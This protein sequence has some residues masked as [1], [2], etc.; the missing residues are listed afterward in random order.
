MGQ[1]GSRSSQDITTISFD[2]QDE[3]TSSGAGAELEPCCE[4]EAAARASHRT[5]GAVRRASTRPPSSA[6]GVS[7]LDA[8]EAA[9][10][11]DSSPQQRVHPANET[12]PL[13]GSSK[14][15]RGQTTGG[16]QRRRPQPNLAIRRGAK[17]LASSHQARI[18]DGPVGYSGALVSTSG[19]PGAG[20]CCCC[21][22]T[23]SAESAPSC[24]HSFGVGGAGYEDERADCCHTE[25][26][27]ERRSTDYQTFVATSRPLASGSYVKPLRA[28]AVVVAP[29]S[30][31]RP[32]MKSSQTNSTSSGG[33]ACVQSAS[34]PVCRSS[35][36]STTTRRSG[37]Q[38][39]ECCDKLIDSCSSSVSP[40]SSNG[41]ELPP[42]GSAHS[43]DHVENDE[44]Q[45]AAASHEKGARRSTATPSTI[46]DAGIRGGDKAHVADKES[47]NS[48][49]ATNTAGLNTNDDSS[50]S[51]TTNNKAKQEEQQ[52]TSYDEGNQNLI[53]PPTASITTSEKRAESQFKQS[54]QPTKLLPAPQPP[55]PPSTD[56]L[57]WNELVLKYGR[58]SQ[59]R[60][61]ESLTIKGA[62]CE[63]PDGDGQFVVGGAPPP[64]PSSRASHQRHNSQQYKQQA[65]G[66]SQQDQYTTSSASTT[67]A[68]VN[69]P[70]RLKGSGPSS[71]SCFCHVLCALAQTLFPILGAFE[72]YSLPGDLFTDLAAGFT[73]AILHI[74]QGMAYGL[75]SGVEPIYGL[76]V[77][78]IPVAVMS[79]MSKSRHVS[80][81]TFAI[82][83][84]LLVNT[85]SEVRSTIR[86]EQASLISANISSPPLVMTDN[87]QPP[88]AMQA[89]QHKSQLLRQ[90]LQQ[91]QHQAPT[92]MNDLSDELVGSPTVARPAIVVASAPASA[93]QQQ[94]QLLVD[95]SS[96]L[97]LAADSMPA[98]PSNIEILSCVCIVC[99]LIHVTMSLLRLGILSLM[100][101]DQLVSSF[102][103][104]GAIHVL[105]SQLAG[106]FDLSLA[107]ISEELFKCARIWWQFFNAMAQGDF[108][109][110]TALLSL[111]SIVFLLTVKE[112]L[113]PTLRRR[114]KRLTCL[115]S[116]LVLMAVLVSMSSYCKLAA[117][118]NVKI[119]GHVPSG[120]PEP[121]LPNLE[122][123]PYVLK[124]SIGVALITFAMNL[125]IAQVY[126]KKFRYQLNANQELFALGSANLVGS[127]FSC[128]PCA[129]SLSRS[130]VQSN[131]NVKSQLCSLFSCCIVFTIVCY[132]AHIL[133]DLP[134]STLSCIIVVALKGILMQVRDLYDNWRLSKLDAT[135]WIVTFVSV[136]VFGVTLGLLLGI[137]ASLFM[138][139][140]RLLTPN[141]S[142]LARLPNT[143]IYIDKDAFLEC[144]E[145]EH[146]K[147]FRFNSALCYLNRTILKSKIEKL[148]P[149]VYEP[150]GFRAICSQFH[151]DQLRQQQHIQHHHR[152]A[153]TIVPSNRINYLV[154]DC[155]ALSYC[156]YSG[157]ATLI[158]L[159]DDLADRKLCVLLAA[160]PLKLIDMIERMPRGQDI[161]AHNV[162][163][164]I[165]GAIGQVKYLQQTTAGADPISLS[166]LAEPTKKAKPAPTTAAASVDDDDDTSKL[167]EQKQQQQYHHHHHHHHQQ[168]G[169]QVGT[170]TGTGGEEE[171]NGS[172]NSIIDVP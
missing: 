99:G 149:S 114:F 150:K 123:V 117:N 51:I 61:Q 134:K 108:N 24:G 171:P 13:R 100:F 93:G 131:L 58:M 88:E 95:T 43:K 20:C 152:H 38:C 121:K 9:G 41:V 160:C 5:V 12:T 96:L 128:F 40:S 118:F 122:L 127:F 126:A 165:G 138:I 143:D 77:S 139:F 31:R 168:A 124:D 157:V 137:L 166:S 141:H 91:Q 23:G 135:V 27:I 120:L 69:R 81:G 163:P 90:L 79:L 104:A 83:S 53:T 103:T 54:T 45:A 107:P 78:F 161:L 89:N 154:I 60:Y 52:V 142:V 169:P 17:K 7:S 151:V 70:N 34:L 55:P 113:E 105:T 156:D 57:T 66:T 110:T 48:H 155:S 130:S 62:V 2:R 56:N 71:S 101:S 6:G 30:K 76:Y 106:L 75:L 3:P 74:P 35:P 80:Y 64:E 115:P 4:I 97:D 148:L 153:E 84:M 1:K 125:S 167:K 82:I 112:L 145:I 22:Q 111:G 116:E 8:R 16:G 147:I 25:S 109:R 46:T 19:T 72:N 162:Y 85:I 28:N 87:H 159:I 172:R 63:Q 65:S 68:I 132:F 144:E 146:V 94:D 47:A 26:S 73:V 86:D 32:L 33:G 140:L 49:N 136:I 129:S 11:G 102:T 37:G 67:Q 119:I 18:G 10:G 42:K 14:L 44:L 50:N 59:G 39:C 21:G 164:T 170:P 133:H 36:Q 29:S 92:T 98:L 158:E 15:D